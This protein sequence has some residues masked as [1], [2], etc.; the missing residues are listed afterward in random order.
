MDGRLPTHTPPAFLRLSYKINCLILVQLAD[1]AHGD[2]G[3]ITDEQ[4]GREQDCETE[5]AYVA[6]RVKE[7]DRD[8]S[9]YPMWVYQ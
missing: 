7:S 1:M 5:E 2:E 6:E 3:Q 9:E 4:E 8:V